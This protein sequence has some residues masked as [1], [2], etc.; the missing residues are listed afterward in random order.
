LCVGCLERRIGR[1]L[2]PHDFADHIFNQHYP[3][4]PRL[5]ERQGRLGSLDGAPITFPVGPDC[6]SSARGAA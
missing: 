1:E 5:M 3:G 4:T 6:L 2:T